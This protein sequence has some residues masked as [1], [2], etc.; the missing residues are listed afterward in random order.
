MNQIATEVLKLVGSLLISVYKR[1]LEGKTQKELAQALNRDESWVSRR[2]RE[3]EKHDLVQVTQEERWGWHYTY[4]TYA[5]WKVHV[6]KLTE[7]GRKVAETL[8]HLDPIIELCPRCRK[9]IDVTGY[10]GVIACPH[11][12]YEFNVEGVEPPRPPTEVPLWV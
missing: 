3:A 7:K 10:S 11:C 4:R 8:L 5:K 1:G 2:V 9:G 12:A 6:I